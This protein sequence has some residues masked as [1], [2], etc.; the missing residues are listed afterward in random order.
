MPYSAVIQ[1]PYIEH[2]QYPGQQDW[3][4]GMESVESWLETRIGHYAVAWIWDIWTLRESHYCSVLF[5]DASSV[6]MFLLRFGADRY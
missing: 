1:W 4:M 6:S 3:V 5:R 2:S